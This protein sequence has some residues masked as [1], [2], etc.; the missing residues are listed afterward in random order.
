MDSRTPSWSGEAGGVRPPPINL[1]TSQQAS[2]PHL[3]AIL[4]RCYAE[5]WRFQGGSVSYIRC[6]FKSVVDWGTSLKTMAIVVLS[7]AH[8][9]L[10]R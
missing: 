4:S 6:L 7:S 10:Y 9:I 3:D 2:R 1:L 8:A 5:H